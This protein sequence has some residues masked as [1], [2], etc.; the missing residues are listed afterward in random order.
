MIK[1]VSLALAAKAVFVIA[2][3]F[4]DFV[5]DSEVSMSKIHLACRRLG[6]LGAVASDVQPLRVPGMFRVILAFIPRVWMPGRSSHCP[7][8]VGIPLL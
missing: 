1:S 4:Q 7:D 6:D 2:K 8:G 3:L 5:S